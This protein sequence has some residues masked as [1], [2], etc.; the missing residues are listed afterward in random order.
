MSAQNNRI[1]VD[2]NVLYYWLFSKNYADLIPATKFMQDIENGKYKGIISDLSLNELRKVIRTQL[3]NKGKTN[4]TE[5]ESAEREA[6]TRIYQLK[7]ENVEIVS[8]EITDDDIK[9]DELFSRV[10]D[11]AYAFMIKYPGKVIKPKTKDEHKG[12]SPVDTFHI[13]LAQN[14]K[15]NKIASFDGDFQVSSSEIPQ[16]VVKQEYRP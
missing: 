14:F 3:V 15:C 16:L 2:T 13:V 4:P 1:Y 11:K 7:K 10:S 8:G 12:L 9:T 6:I 5:W